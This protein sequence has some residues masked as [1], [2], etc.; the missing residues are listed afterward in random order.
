MGITAN[1]LVGVAILSVKYPVG[2]EYVECGYT[3]DGA[4]MEYSPDIADIE[5]A[6]ETFPIARVITKEDVSIT[7]NLLEATLDNMNKAFAGS[8]LTT[9]SLTEDV[10]TIG[11]GVIKQLGVKLVGKTPAGKDRTI[12]MPL[13]TAV[14][15]VAIPYKK[16]EKTVIPV[17]FGA[18]K[19]AAAPCTV[20]DAK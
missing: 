3:E 11:G 19:G 4:V 18:L 12:E 9:D 17:K 6:E 13:A 1:V 10:I 14:G 15:A 8:I 2:G 16:G 20:S 7:A 5:V